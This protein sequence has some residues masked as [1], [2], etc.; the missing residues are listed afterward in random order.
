MSEKTT[1]SW[2]DS[3][4]NPILAD[5]DGKIGYH[6]ERVSPECTSC[7]AASFNRRTLPARG[8]GLDYTRSAR[9]Q[10]RIFLD[11]KTLA[12]P[13]HWRKPR[14]IFVCSMTDL[15]AE[16]VTDEM[17]DRVFAVMALCGQHTFQCLTKRPE[18][19]R[20]YMSRLRGP[21]LIWATAHRDEAAAVRPKGP[22]E[23]AFRWPL[24]NVWLG[25]TA[26][27]QQ[28]ANERNPELIKIPAAVRFMSIEPMLEAIRL[29]IGIYAQVPHGQDRGTTLEGIGWVICGCESGPKR[30]PMERQWARDLR[31]QCKSAG[32][33]FFMKQMQVDGKVTEDIELFPEDLRVREFP[34]AVANG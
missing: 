16:F 8:T 23:I 19:M 31:D 32:V 27:D 9:D 34:K 13:L 2:T 18:R 15:F 4:W 5:R 14:R 28:R 21:A 1:I 30:R 33:P 6:C 11:D 24:P 12:K 3:T 17:I 22:N 10:V 7:Y 20:A 29:R 25:T 26:G